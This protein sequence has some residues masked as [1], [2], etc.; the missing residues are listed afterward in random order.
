MNKN[1]PE[2]TES[3]F[4]FSAAKTFRCG[5]VHLQLRLLTG[6]H[7][8]AANNLQYSSFNIM[9]C[10]LPVLVQYS[11]Q[12]ASTAI[13]FSYSFLIFSQN[14]SRFNLGRTIFSNF[15]WEHALRLPSKGMLSVLY[16]LSKLGQH[17]AKLPT[18]YFFNFTD[19]V[20]L[21]ITT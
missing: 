13:A 12:V 6:H 14:C 5:S 7:S 4:C 16:I 11:L 3:P 2:T 10:H 19:V 18:S 8:I 17:S 9:V 1:F 15:S 21:T 20:M